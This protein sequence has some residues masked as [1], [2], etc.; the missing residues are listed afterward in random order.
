MRSEEMRELRL[1][2]LRTS[3]S[4]TTEKRDGCVHKHNF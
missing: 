3:G 2:L 1:S 4:F